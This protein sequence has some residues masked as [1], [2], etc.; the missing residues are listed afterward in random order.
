MATGASHRRVVRKT[1]RFGHE[2]H[3]VM[4]WGR[5]KKTTNSSSKPHER[6][7]WKCKV[8]CFLVSRFCIEVTGHK[9]KKVLKLRVKS[10]SEPFAGVIQN[11][12]F[13]CI[14]IEK[15]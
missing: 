6:N 8:F 1:Q 10:T 11:Y 13:L 4:K 3:P 5:V 15:S 2:T 7:M 9:F 12:V 14:L